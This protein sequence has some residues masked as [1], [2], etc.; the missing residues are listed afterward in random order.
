MLEEYSKSATPYDFTIESVIITAKRWEFASEGIDIKNVC[1]EINLF[2]H[3]DKPYL[4]ANL[5]FLD[6][7]NIGDNYQFTGTERVQITLISSDER[8]DAGKN[9]IVKDII[10]H[11]LCQL[12]RYLKKLNLEEDLMKEDLLV[13]LLK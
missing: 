11:V 12:I 9:T 7:A 8:D 3:L 2:E 13:V 5:T 6:N 4:T 1:A 10:N